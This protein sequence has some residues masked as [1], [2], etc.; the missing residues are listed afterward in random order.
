MTPEDFRQA[1]FEQYAEEGDTCDDAW[2]QNYFDSSSD[3]LELEYRAADEGFAVYSDPESDIGGFW[4]TL[5]AGGLEGPFET[6]A[7]L[8]IALGYSPRNF[9]PDADADADEADI[10]EDFD[11]DFDE[12]PLADDDEDEGDEDEDGDEDFDEDED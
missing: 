4:A 9:P 10:D 1:Y 3:W 2:F 6:M 12:D 11:D 8:A 5:A 7:E